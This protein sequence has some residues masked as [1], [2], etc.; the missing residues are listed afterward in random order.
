MSLFIFPQ[1]GSVGSAGLI[2]NMRSYLWIRVQQ[3]TGRALRVNLLKHLHGLS[4][5]WHLGRKTGWLQSGRILLQLQVYCSI[6][7]TVY[8][9]DG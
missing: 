4:L 6:H 2:N 8:N 7:A 5:R 9:W 1:G 3:Y